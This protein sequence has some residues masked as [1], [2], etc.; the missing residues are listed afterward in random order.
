M[1]L[2][3]GFKQAGFKE[4]QPQTGRP[5]GRDRGRPEAHE[6]PENPCPDGYPKYF[7]DKERKIARPAIVT[8]EARERADRFKTDKLKR[9]QLRAFYDH[10]KR[11]LQRLNYGA[12]FEEVRFEIARL[13]PLAADR[14]GRSDNAIPGS[15]KQFIDCNVDAVVDEDSFR[16]GFM[17]HFEAVVAYC[18]ILRD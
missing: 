7:D 16:K 14:A 4:S 11:Q 17:P 10:A 8:T 6:R 2:R 18:A 3:E 5:G 15:F 13:Q 1:D 12:A 9:H